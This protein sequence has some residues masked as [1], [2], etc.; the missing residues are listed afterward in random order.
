MALVALQTSVMR[1]DNN[2]QGI[3]F[4]D[5]YAAIFGA[6]IRTGFAIRN[7]IGKRAKYEE[8]VTLYGINFL[9]NREWLEYAT[10]PIRN[11]SGK[12]KNGKQSYRT[13]TKQPVT[14]ELVNRNGRWYVNAIIDEPIEQGTGSGNGFLGLDI[15]PDSFDWAVVDKH[16][17]LKVRGSIKTN[18]QFKNS[19]QTAD[20]LGKAVA[21][22]V[23]IYR[24]YS[25]TIAIEDLD[26]AQKKASLKERSTKY[27]RMLSNFAYSKFTQLIE[28]RTQRQGVGRVLVDAAYTS[29]IGVT[30][31]MAMYGINSGCAAAL[32]IARR[33][34]LISNLKTGANVFLPP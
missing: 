7:T 11:P 3:D 31:Y 17:D 6:A 5:D 27:A 10:T 8:S 9:D 33:L 25:V 24:R 30:K 1:S 21:S 22:V 29:V 23:R 16:G 20:I 13:G 34:P 4:L 15:N 12:P 32:V 2:Q 14:Y 19:N 28:T 26:F 18:I